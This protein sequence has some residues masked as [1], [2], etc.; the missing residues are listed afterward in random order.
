MN[1]RTVVIIAGIL[2]AGIAF[3]T[4]AQTPERNMSKWSDN[5][6]L[7]SPSGDKHKMKAHKV[8]VKPSV[9]QKHLHAKHKAKAH[10]KHHAY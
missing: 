9:K 10:K 8:K 3:N 6:T 2:V 5:V 1:F 4:V 7:S